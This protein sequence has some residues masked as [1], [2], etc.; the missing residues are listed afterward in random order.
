M[1]NLNSTAN[2]KPHA[3]EDLVTKAARFGAMGWV[4]FLITLLTLIAQN[5]FYAL[6]PEKVMAAENGTVIGQVTFNETRYRTN[7]DVIAD[8]KHWTAKCVS[9]N[10]ISIYED[11]SGCVMHM[12]KPLADAKVTA[13]EKMNYAPTIEAYGCEKTSTEFDMKKTVLTKKEDAITAEIY[14]DVICNTPGEKP[15]SQAFAAKVEGVLL[16]KTTNRPLGIKITS[17]GDI[18]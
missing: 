3:F 7:D 16:P 2:S 15:K 14:G 11:L 9:M 18:E 4:A 1:E 12:D 6:K 8:L 17:Y 10:K 13:Y 5:M